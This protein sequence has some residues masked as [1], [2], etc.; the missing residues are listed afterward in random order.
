MVMDVLIPFAE[1]L[2]R[3]R[4]FGK[5]VETSEKEMEGMRDLNLSFGRASYICCRGQR[6][7]EGAESRSLGLERD[8]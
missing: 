3:D 4:D 8:H 5:A 6:G 2:N 7:A 1:T